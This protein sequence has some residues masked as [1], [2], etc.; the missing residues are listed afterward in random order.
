MDVLQHIRESITQDMLIE[1]LESRGARGICVSGDEI[2]CSC[3][4]HHGN[5]TTAFALDTK[6][7]LWNCFTGSCGG[8]DI[9]DLIR[10]TSDGKLSWKETVAKTAQIFEV[11][12]EGMAICDRPTIAA[13]ITKWLNYRKAK[14]R[15]ANSEY[16]LNK[17]GRFDTIGNYRGLTQDTIKHFGLMY[18]IDMN[19]V[20]VPVKDEHGI[21]VGASLRRVNEEEKIKWLHRPKGI[22][23]GL[24]LYNLDNVI[25]IQT[26]EVYITEGPFDVIKAHQLGLK[27]VVATYGAHMTTKQEELVMKYFIRVVL[28][29]DN[30]TAGQIATRKAIQQLKHKTNLYVLDL[31]QYKDLGE[32]ENTECLQ[33]LKVL[34]YHEWEECHGQ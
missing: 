17:L 11:D 18:S 23:T 21:I 29:Y 3:P 14:N 12:I 19:R 30:D 15:S 7:L 4:V 9:F 31:Q 16:D 10:K 8:G 1:F 22:D 27:N 13:D 6:R 34:H 2:R 24:I 32:V 20:M 25:N 33:Q 26:S 28:A 5:N